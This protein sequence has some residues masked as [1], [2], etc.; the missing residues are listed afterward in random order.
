[1]ET[2]YN[3]GMKL[4][5]NADIDGDKFVQRMLDKELDLAEIEINFT[6]DRDF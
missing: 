2:L 5:E 1:M 4:V 3:L 6:S